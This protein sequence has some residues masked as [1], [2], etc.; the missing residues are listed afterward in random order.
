MA[1]LLRGWENPKNFHLI[2]INRK[3]LIKSQ[4]SLK[5]GISNYQMGYGDLTR[6]WGLQ[7]PHPIGYW[8]VKSAFRMGKE[9]QTVPDL[10]PPKGR[11]L[12]CPVAPSLPPLP[13]VVPARDRSRPRRKSSPAV[14]LA[15]AISRLS[16]EFAKRSHTS[17]C[18]IC[19]EK[20][21][22]E[23]TSSLISTACEKRNKCCDQPVKGDRPRRG[24]TPNILYGDRR[25]PSPH[26]FAAKK[27]CKLFRQISTSLDYLDRCDEK[28]TVESTPQ[29]QS[30]GSKSHI[31]RK[32]AIR[33]CGDRVVNGGRP[34]RGSTPNIYLGER[35]PPSPH[36]FAARKGW[37]LSRQISTSLDDLDRCDEN[38]NLEN[39]QQQCLNSKA[40][41]S[42][43]PTYKELW[44]ST[45]VHALPPG[46]VQRLKTKPPGILTSETD[47]VSKLSLP[48]MKNQNNR[49]S[50][51]MHG[52]AGDV[53]KIHDDDIRLAHDHGRRGSFDATGRP[54]R[55]T[56]ASFPQ[57]C[58][59]GTKRRTCRRRSRS[60]SAPRPRSV[61]ANPDRLSDIPANPDRLSNRLSSEAQMA[62]LGAYTDEIV[63]ELAKT[64]DAIPGWLEGMD[65]NIDMVDLPEGIKVCKIEEGMDILDNMRKHREDGKYL[66]LLQQT[67]KEFEQW[68]A[69]F[70]KEI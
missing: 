63:S 62:V 1:S 9:R 48:C 27:G 46:V 60:E 2:Q 69:S 34:R 6:M 14:T 33:G 49:C 21:S 4:K 24:S 44:A 56:F 10:L 67:V 22:V 58:Q 39:S 19:A 38:D 40:H 20:I 12:S 28:Q 8:C 36:P 53:S 5:I 30:L 3:L 26:P 68:R 32:P 15:P 64:G 66:D 29:E 41:F 37:G 47:T 13:D 65:V 18:N 23:S 52:Y 7:E 59:P 57:I 70:C 43:K 51:I 25:P 45:G 50:V 55:V 61:P 11:R 35:R 31:T 54:N 17:R 16:P 42:R